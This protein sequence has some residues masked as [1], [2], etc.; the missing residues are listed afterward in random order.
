MVHMAKMCALHTMPYDQKDFRAIFCTVY[1]ML[2]LMHFLVLKTYICHVTKD[3]N[4]LKF[5]KFNNF[6]LKEDCFFES[7]T[8]DEQTTPFDLAC[9]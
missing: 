7:E 3:C 1:P 4:I 5:E 6:P 9:I 8:V 2:C